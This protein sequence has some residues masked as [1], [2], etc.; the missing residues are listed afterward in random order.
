MKLQA[1]LTVA[2]CKK[3][4]AKAIASLPEVRRALKK[5]KILLKGG[6]TVSALSEEMLG[7]PLW[8]SGRITPRGTKMSHSSPKKQPHSLLIVK[9]VVE[10]GFTTFDSY[11]SS[12]SELGE[13]DIVVVGANAIDLQGNAAIMVG[14]PLGG[15]P[16]RVFSGMMGEGAEVIIAASLE[17]L[18]PGSIREAVMAAGRRRMDTSFGMAVG[19]VPLLGRIITEDRAVEILAD[20]R[21]TV[22]GRGGIEGAEGSTT[23]VIE[24]DRGE[25]ERILKIISE[26]KMAETS[27]INESLI[28]CEPGSRCNWAC[29]RQACIYHPR[30][31]EDN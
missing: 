29:I 13:D 31:T 16:G 18:I 11:E 14:A 5:G 30:D 21:C 27:G 15:N 2:E 24:G 4:I 17:K 10:K 20:V 7:K 9:G 25:V 19:L 8:I 3:I 23:M 12:V 22:I 26:M 28:E 6:T 1:T